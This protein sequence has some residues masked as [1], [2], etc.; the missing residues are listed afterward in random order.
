MCNCCSFNL[1]RLS[2]RSHSHDTKY[3]WYGRFRLQFRRHVHGFSNLTDALVNNAVLV[4][5]QILVRQLSQVSGIQSISSP[6]AVISLL[7]R[8]FDLIRHQQARASVIWLVGQ[9]AEDPNSK[10]I[11][12]WAPDVLR[13]SVIP[14]TEEVIESPLTK[15]LM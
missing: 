10:G 5:K 4:I 12:E 1:A 3:T 7:A 6:V 8:K 14:F 2:C 9:Y 13:R 11:I 15:I